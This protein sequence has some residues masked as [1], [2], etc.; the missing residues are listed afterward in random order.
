[1]S[2]AARPGALQP[3]PATPI[4]FGK[5]D[6]VCRHDTVPVTFTTDFSEDVCS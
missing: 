6:F 1:M 3:T 4:Q 2:A 5:D